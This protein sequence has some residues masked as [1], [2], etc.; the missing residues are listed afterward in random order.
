MGRLIV[1]GVILPAVTSRSIGSVF[2]T[3]I[4]VSTRGFV[5]MIAVVPGGEENNV[6]ASFGSG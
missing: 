4:S 2:A 5:E 3:V 6:G 1:D